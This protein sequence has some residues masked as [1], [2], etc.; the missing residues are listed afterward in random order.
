MKD[1]RLPVVDA[2]ELRADCS[3][4]VGLC[5]VVP[6][7][8]ASADFAL[9]KPAGTAC[10]NLRTD[11]RCAIHAELRP[12]GFAGCTVFDCF[13]AGQTVTQVTFGGRDWR[14]SPEVAGP[15]FAV[16]P[17][18]RALHE[19]LWHLDHALART[20]VEPVRARLA[21]ASDR[22]VA[23][24][25]TSP[26]VLVQVDTEAERRAVDPLLQEVSLLV[27]TAVRPVPPD[28]RRADLIGADL[29]DTD[30]RGADLSGA[31]F[32]TQM[33]VQAARGD[34][35]TR[36]PAALDRP[37]HWTAERPRTTATK[38]TR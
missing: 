23:L 22:L 3:R 35:A 34:A 8:V 9:T 10:P 4:C 37:A 16:F 13:G 19:L 29:R 1:P 38:S 26:D 25:A 14:S 7:F 11:H 2:P 5:C 17:V 28:R 6:A 12:R 21:A 32:V 30:L 33:Q 24:T 36:I 20:G 27:R 31:L 18:V 15:M